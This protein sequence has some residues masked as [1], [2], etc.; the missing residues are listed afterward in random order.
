MNKYNIGDIILDQ[1]S[2][3]IFCIIRLLTDGYEVYAIKGIVYNK[4]NFLHVDSK[5]II[6]SILL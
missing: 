6:D 2:N 1:Y 3:R 4:E 5:T